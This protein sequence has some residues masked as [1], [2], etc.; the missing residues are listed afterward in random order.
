MAM[1]RSKKSRVSMGFVYFFIFLVLLFTML[2]LVYLTVTAFKPLD[3]LF[4]WPPKFYTFRPT[5]S[6]FTSLFTAMSG[7]S[8]P[9]IRYVFNSLFTTVISVIGTLVVCGMAAY[10]MSKF[11]YPGSKLLFS[12]VVAAL[13]FS[14][15]VTQISTYMVVTKMNMNDT[16][17]VLILPKLATAMYL[18][19]TKQ[20]VDQIPDTYIESA[21]IDGAGEWRIFVKIIIPMIKPALMTVV[22]FAFT[23]FW[24]D[25]FS[26]MVYT[27]SDA[28]KTLP[29][30]L[31]TI[32]SNIMRTG[33][34]NAA[35][36]LMTVPT[37]IVFVLMQ[38]RVMETMIYSGIKG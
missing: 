6:N 9:F 2:P 5:L 36:F 24:N 4:V 37:I 8:V 32:G 25:F 16:Y 3:E 33:A 17:L 26:P 19:L 18:F 11:R 34:N 28:M 10:G 20:F 7:F 21:R 29:L 31:Q 12:L 1:V 22:V 35:A 23:A 14:P 30:A 13:M 27:T 38:K 15:Q